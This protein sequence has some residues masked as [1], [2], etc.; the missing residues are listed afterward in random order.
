MR[1]SAREARRAALP[2]AYAGSVSTTIGAVVGAAEPPAGSTVTPIAS[3][4]DS[5]DASTGAVP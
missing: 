3:P 4:P 1:Q 5:P 2:R